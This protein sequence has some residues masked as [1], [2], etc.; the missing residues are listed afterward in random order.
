MPDTRGGRWSAVAAIGLPV[1]GAVATVGLW[2]LVI[3]AFGIESYVA[4]TP[5][6]VAATFG[7]M[8]GYLLENA[9]VTLVETL[10]GFAITIVAGVLVGTV[11]AGSRPVERAFMP[12]LVA[13]NAVPKL[14]F[15]T[16]LIV[17]MG[18]GRGPKVVM[19]I[20]MCFFPI[21]L[22]TATGL[23][24]TPAELVE[25]ARALSA[26]RWQ[27]FAKIRFPAAL[28]QVFIGLKVAMPLAVIGALVGELFGST[29][30]LGF[31]IQTA[32]ADTA[33]SFAAIVLLALMSMVLFYALVAV[34][35]LLVPWVPETTA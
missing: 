3:I 4:P 33:L 9:W 5:P 34:E 21:V 24:R 7:R 6:E 8:P 13:L 22:A 16:L 19:V 30:G 35:R 17:W 18:Y 11:L 28:P 23:T 32:G 20:L 15:A 26:S 31:V 14:A 10:L 1:G 25:L 29:A 2:W 12:T 27:A